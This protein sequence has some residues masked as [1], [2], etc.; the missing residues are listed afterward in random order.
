MRYLLIILSLLSFIFSQI[1]YIFSDNIQITNSSNNQKFPEMIINNNIIHLTWVSVYG[2][3]KNIMYSNSND[4]GET[5]SEP[6]QVNYFNN[7][8]VAYGQSGPKIEVFNGNIFI[9]YIDNR[10]GSWSPY[11]NV[12]YDNGLTCK[13]KLCFQKPCI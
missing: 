1:E 9:T 4:F 8:I 12:S 5:F 6:I 3:T 13:K 10:T 7:H 11:L 2:N